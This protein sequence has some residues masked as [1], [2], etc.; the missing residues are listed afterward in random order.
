MQAVPPLSP[1]QAPLRA[2]SKETEMYSSLMSNIKYAGF[3]NPRLL[4]NFK[5]SVSS[6][7]LLAGNA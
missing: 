2:S 3:W 5:V 1:R 7:D 6:A 4:S